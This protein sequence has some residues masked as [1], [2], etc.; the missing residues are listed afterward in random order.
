MRDHRVFVECL[1][2]GHRVAPGKAGVDQ[3]RVD[4]ELQSSGKVRGACRIDPPAI[5]ARNPQVG[6][7]GEDAGAVDGWPVLA[8]VRRRGH[9]RSGDRRPRQAFRSR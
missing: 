4:R 5:Q 7:L 6:A 8:A 1:P 2:L 9:P 3:S